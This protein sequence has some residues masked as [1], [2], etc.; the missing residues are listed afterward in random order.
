MTRVFSI[1]YDY[2]CP[3]ARNANEHVLDG[4]EAGA[5]WDVRFVPFS[6]SQVHADDDGKPDVWDRDDPL[7][8]AGIRAL[9]AGLVVRQRDPGRFPDVHRSLFAARHDDGDD[10]RDP[11]VVAGALSRAGVDADEIL[12]EVGGLAVLDTLRKEH[13]AA[14]NQHDVFGVPTFITDD[15]AVFVRVM[16]RPEGDSDV[17]IRTVERLLDA[18]TGWVDLNEF[19]RTSIPR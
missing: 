18:L 17:A 9:L 13:E 19:K 2:L 11:E 12:T 15:E 3:F 10:I 8:S 6:L 1:T 4:L 14:E 7:R 5:D 16:H